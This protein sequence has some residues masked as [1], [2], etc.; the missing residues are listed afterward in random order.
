MV[1]PLAAGLNV[2]CSIGK[3]TVGEIRMA[4]DEKAQ[5]VQPGYSPGTNQNSSG[6]LHGNERV[7]QLKWLGGRDSSPAKFPTLSLRQI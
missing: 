7:K 1:V 5:V 4:A 3:P 2:I 6:Q